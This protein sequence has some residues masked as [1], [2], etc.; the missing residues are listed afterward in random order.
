MDLREESARLD[1]VLRL[2]V[3]SWHDELK[4]VEKQIEQL[5]AVLASSEAKGDRSENA[6]FQIAK[7]DRDM[8]V[9]KQRILLNKIAAY[10]ETRKEYV[11]T[12]KIT[13]G[14]TVELTIK[15]INGVPFANSN[16]K[17]IFKIV[18]HDLCS[19]KKGLLARDSRAGLCL[20]N[21]TEGECVQAVAI[22]GTVTYKIERIY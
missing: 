16:H 13:E 20:L 3:S 1:E 21:H 4:E 14:S 19:A 15:A 12:G 17:F 10:D 2:E 6:V 18:P 8:K 5:N 11:P 9:E 7:D 22:A